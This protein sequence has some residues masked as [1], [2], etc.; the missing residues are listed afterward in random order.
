VR[1]VLKQTLWWS[2]GGIAVLLLLVIALACWL[3]FTTAGARWV[4]AQVTSR[5]APQVKYAQLDGTIAGELRIRDF[6]FTGPP[7]AAQIRIAQLSV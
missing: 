4:A 5:F 7:D 2:G 6:Q 3:L 1:P